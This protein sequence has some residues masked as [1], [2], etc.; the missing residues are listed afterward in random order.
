MNSKKLT[1]RLLSAI[2]A[3]AVAG[4]P[5][6]TTAE[7]ID[8]FVGNAGNLG[9]QGIPNVMIV[10]DNSSN[11]SANN[12]GWKDSSGTK[13][14]Q[15]QAEVRAI[16]A[17]LAGIT[18]VNVGL[19]LYIDSGS[20]GGS[21]GTNTGSFVNVG[22]APLELTRTAGNNKDQLFLRLEAI[23]NDITNPAYKTSSSMAYGPGL[24]DAVNFFAG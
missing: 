19:M 15:G 6:N 8:I 20:G 9:T 5:L 22:L 24:F 12:Q 4:L 17:A 16:K 18:G 10:I 3:F 23:D 1:S 2:T 14:T 13:Y 7:D 11:F 21:S